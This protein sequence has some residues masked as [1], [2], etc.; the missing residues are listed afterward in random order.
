[1]SVGLHL[2][3]QERKHQT[4]V[5]QI[6]RRTPQNLSHFLRTSITPRMGHKLETFEGHQ[7]FMGMAVSGEGWIGTHVTVRAA[8][9]LREL[10]K[11][12]IE[13]SVRGC[14]ERAGNLQMSIKE[15]L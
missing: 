2:K 15:L 4:P 9:E 1:M 11:L 12:V 10:R 14:Q 6:P 13:Y 7:D 3:F 5:H 8:G